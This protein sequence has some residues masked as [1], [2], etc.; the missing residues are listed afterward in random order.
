MAFTSETAKVA[1][2]KA[3]PRGESKIKKLFLQYADKEDV[4]ELFDKL[5]VMA[6]SGDM[7]AI[8]TMLAYLIG[9]PKE[10]VDMKLDAE[11]TQKTQPSWARML[12]E[13]PSLNHISIINTGQQNGS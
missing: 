13:D 8:K 10:T 6:L 5:K 12:T 3:K 1:A 9:K 4:K 11:F 2:A 7:D